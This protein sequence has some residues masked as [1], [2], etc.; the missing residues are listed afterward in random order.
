MTNVF[1]S[2][3]K[4]S[5]NTTKCFLLK[6]WEICFQATSVNK[7]LIG[8]FLRFRVLIT[9]YDSNFCCL[10]VSSV[11]LHESRLYTIDIHVKC[12]FIGVRC[13]FLNPCECPNTNFK[14]GFWCNRFIHKSPN[15]ILGQF[16]GWL[17]INLPLFKAIDLKQKHTTLG[18]ALLLPIIF[19]SLSLSSKNYFSSVA[20]TLHFHYL[21]IKSKVFLG[22]SATH[23]WCTNQPCVNYNLL[24]ILLEQNTA[25]VSHA[26]QL[27]SHRREISSFL[28][29]LIV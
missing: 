3:R 5:N 4:H 7:H 10:S 28:Y 2:S 18:S 27:V 1:S 13:R 26:C 24:R 29:N 20:K 25:L 9:Y 23:W 17:V 12:G 16:L 11:F 21:S 14:I 6:P 19:L 22:R 8:G 15:I